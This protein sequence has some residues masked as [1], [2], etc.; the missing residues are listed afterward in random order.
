MIAQPLMAKEPWGKILPPLEKCTSDKLLSTFCAPDTHQGP[1]GQA[2]PSQLLPP[3]SL[4]GLLSP[5]AP[6]GSFLPRAA[7]FLQLCHGLESLAP[8]RPPL[9]ACLSPGPSSLREPPPQCFPQDP[10]SP[11]T[12]VLFV[13][14]FSVSGT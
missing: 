4:A 6:P 12:G 10:R 9:P 1:G 13:F 5:L 3:L 8:S 11:L 2:G 14:G 7:P